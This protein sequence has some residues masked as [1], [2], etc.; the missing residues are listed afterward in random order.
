MTPPI[1]VAGTGI[2]AAGRRV[3]WTVSEGHKGRRWRELVADAS[4]IRH[5]LL[6]ETGPDRRFTHLEIAAADGLWTFHPEADGT[7]HGNAFGGA[8]NGVRHID[9]WPFGPAA[10]LLVTGSLISAA[11]I[12][13]HASGSVEAGGGVSVP[14]VVWGVGDEGL[15]VTIAIAIERRSATSWRIGDAPVVEIDGDGLPVLEA[16]EWHPLERS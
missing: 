6:L 8:T 5:S 13:W 3:T 4:G 7:L 12:A 2:D 14:G 9:G 10:I 15:E 1:R 16:A 11:S